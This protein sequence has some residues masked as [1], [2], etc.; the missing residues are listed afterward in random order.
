MALNVCVRPAGRGS[1]GGL[2]V[3][4]TVGIFT[5]PFVPQAT[6]ENVLPD[7]SPVGTGLPVIPQGAS[8]GQTAFPA[9]V[10]QTCAPLHVHPGAL[11]GQSQVSSDPGA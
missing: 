10:T 4:T 6:L 7:P 11:P 8:W 5:L 1:E 3:S 9:S 2:P